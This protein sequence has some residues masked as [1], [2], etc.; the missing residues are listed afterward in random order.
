[1]TEPLTRPPLPLW[2]MSL[3]DQREAQFQEYLTLN[4][5]YVAAIRE[6]GTNLGTAAT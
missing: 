4:E 2:Q 1:M 6:A 3:D 5:P